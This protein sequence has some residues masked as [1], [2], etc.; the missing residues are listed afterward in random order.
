MANLQS[1][2]ITNAIGLTLLVGLLITSYLMR[3]RH[4]L[5]DRMFTAMI[6]LCMGSCI[7]EPVT[8]LVDG[9]PEPWA[10]A[11]NYLGN[12]YCY[13]ATN[14]Y[15]YLWVLYVDLRLHRGTEH[16]RSWHRVLLVPTVILSLAIIGNL[17]G[18][19]LFSID[20]GNVY[21]R[22]PLSYINY[23]M[24]CISLFYS[25]GIRQKYQREHGKL[26]FFPIAMFLVPVFAGSILQALLFGVSLAWPC[27][28][29][30]LVCIHM[31]QQN[32][33]TYLDPLTGLYNRTYLD[34]PLRTLKTGRYSGGGMMIDMD[35]FKDINDTFGHSVGD[36]ALV[37]AASILKESVPDDALV[38]RFAGDEFI[39]LLKDDNGV[40]AQQVEASIRSAVDAFNRE[41]GQPYKLSLSIGH[42]LFNAETDTVDEFLRRIDER[43]YDEKRT[44]HSERGAA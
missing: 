35:Y 20:E 8:W 18:H 17:F 12:T 30:G 3:E 23:V 9:R 37:Q 13:L 32:E 27:V 10:F 31:S 39:V 26:H 29:I 42:S 34:F 6:F 36:Q 4:H 38:I 11:L 33:L 14:I 25:I 40:I 19:Y 1:I 15:A 7:L 22:L 16:I 43:M 44:K 2:I 5:D 21:H 24:V 28:S 41:G